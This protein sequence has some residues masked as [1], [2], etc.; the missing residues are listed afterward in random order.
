M[1]LPGGWALQHRF[2]NRLN[3]GPADLQPAV[4]QVCSVEVVACRRK[5]L[6]GDRNE[7]RNRS[8]KWLV[9][10]PRNHHYPQFH[11]GRVAGLAEVQQAGQGTVNFEGYFAAGLAGV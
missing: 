3:S 2:R 5:H 8:T 9:S 6:P 1:S 7:S 10:C 4:P 11:F